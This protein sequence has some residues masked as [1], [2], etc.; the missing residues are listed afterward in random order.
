[1]KILFIYDAIAQWGGIERVWVE[2][3]N[4]LADQYNYDVSLLTTIQGQHPV[5]YNLSKRVKHTDL[6]IQFHY[7]YRYNGIRKWY[8]MF[9]RKRLFVKRLKKYLSTNTPDIITG[10]AT[11]YVSELIRAK[12]NIPLVSESHDIYDSLFKQSITKWYIKRS[13]LHSLSK[14]DT[15]VALTNGDAAKWR[16]LNPKVQVIANIVHLNNTNKYSTMNNNRIIFAGRL[17]EQK[18]IYSLLKIWDIIHNR[19]KDWILDIYGEGEMHDLLIRESDKYDGSLV[20]HNPTPDIFQSYI[21]SS[22]SV[23]TSKYESFG[24]VIPEA[25]SCGLPVVS[26]DCPCGPRDIITEGE[27]GYLVQ[28]GDCKTF[29]DKVCYLIEHPEERL[30]M[31]KIAVK[32]AQRYKPENIMPKWIE[33]YK[34]LTNEI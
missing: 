13:I 17:V 22:I 34:S 12:G 26:F 24:L 8:E 6:A 11:C 21:N 25:M 4:I 10:V 15:I 3:M 33:L 16:T 18:G 23:L 30:R 31:G 2:R 29:A 7:A 27:D 28:L 32:S 20:V 1:M 14:S 19:H 9:K 5:P